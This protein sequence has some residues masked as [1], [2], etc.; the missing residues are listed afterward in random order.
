MVIT[1]VLEWGQVL[2]SLLRWRRPY[3]LLR[4]IFDKEGHITI[5]NYLF[6]FG[7]MKGSRLMVCSSIIHEFG[8]LFTHYF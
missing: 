1:C 3:L 2:I 6:W 4:V 8:K 7:F 5:T